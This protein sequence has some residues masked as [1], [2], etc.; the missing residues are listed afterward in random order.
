MIKKKTF[1][2]LECAELVAS[3]E[4]ARLKGD[5]ATAEKTCKALLSADSDHFAAVY[6]LGLIQSD[7]GQ[8]RRAIETLNRAFLLHPS[9][10]PTKLALSLAYLEMK[11]FESARYWAE[12]SENQQPENPLNQQALGEICFGQRNYAQ[13]CI[14]FEN[15]SEAGIS[16]AYE[17]AG[18]ARLEL[19]DDVEA[20]KWLEEAIRHAGITLSKAQ[21]Y[22]QLPKS[23]RSNL[24]DG[25]I[26]DFLLKSNTEDDRFQ[27]L[28][29]RLHEG[30]GNIDAAW[31]SAK[32]G[33]NQVF[34]TVR[35]AE[36]REAGEHLQRAEW[37][38]RNAK[39]FREKQP[40]EASVPISLFIIGPSRSGKT[41]VER[42]LAQHPRVKIG[43]ES[44]VLERTLRVT[45]QEAGLP[46]S[47]SFASL[48]KEGANR[49]KD[50]YLAAIC[51]SK[52]DCDVF[53]TTT[54]GYIWEAPFLPRHIPNV[55]FI[56][57][58]RKRADLT[59]RIFQKRYAGQ[60]NP[61]SYDIAAIG[62]H[63]DT[64]DQ[65]TR[66]L[67]NF[68]PERVLSL[69]YE[70]VV[71]DPSNAQAMIYEFCCL[72]KND[73]SPTVDLGDDTDCAKAFL[74]YLLENGL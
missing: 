41:S 15:A 6:T 14:H 69:N 45:S 47:T 9:H 29:S 68:Y 25:L 23:L 35:S 39:L 16:E 48:T 60:G 64:Y 50:S 53:T 63:L 22:L 67:E 40:R 66:A 58:R 11:L 59:W 31:L 34:Q 52:D 5:L 10:W 44:S 33:N 55:Q 19:G 3:A 21:T 30:E 32:K 73:S 72:Q 57:V 4:Q 49:F 12:A 27:F 28:L 8:H 26:K 62:R 42:L 70:D 51:A 46:S 18:R 74:P 38:E 56:N 20:K 17:W 54:P 36:L 13:S 2:P 24:L 7:K 37:F 65:V 61:Y 1:T 71:T 43:Y